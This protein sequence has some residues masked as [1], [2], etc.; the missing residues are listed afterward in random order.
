MAT[1]AGLQVRDRIF[2]AGEWVAPAGDETIQ[3][4]NL[5]I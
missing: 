1:A 2:V 3:V 4:V 5:T